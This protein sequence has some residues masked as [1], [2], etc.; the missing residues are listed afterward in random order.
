MLDEFPLSY[1][2]E[3]KYVGKNHLMMTG[4]EGVWDLKINNGKVNSIF[5][6]RDFGDYLLSGAYFVK[7]ADRLV[8]SSAIGIYTYEP[9]WN[10]NKKAP[11]APT[12]AEIFID[13]VKCN[14][15]SKASICADNTLSMY[16]RDVNWG[17]NRKLYYRLVKKGQK[18]NWIQLPKPEI[19]LSNLQKGKYTL[20][21]KSK[22][23]SGESNVAEYKLEIQPFWYNNNWFY[24]FVLFLS[25]IAIVIAFNWRSRLSKKKQIILSEIIKEKTKEIAKEKLQIESELEQKGILLKEVNHR[26]MNNMQMVSSVLELQSGRAHSEKEKETLT[27]AIQRVKAL[28][29]AHQHFYQKNQFEKINLKNYLEVILQ[30]LIDKKTIGLKFSIADDIEMNIEQAQ[31]LG[32]ILNELLSNSIKH[33]WSL[34]APDKKIDFKF[35]EEKGRYQFEYRDN[36]SGLSQDVGSSNGIGKMLIN[37]FVERKLNGQKETQNDNG[38]FV[39][40]SFGKDEK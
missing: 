20:G 26:V 28:A 19:R 4:S 14:N 6:G 31:T 3:A 9:F 8:Y 39:K 18:S 7:L 22:N 29:L 13:S 27:S 36:G 25:S 30:S 33:A 40:I 1:I 2:W 24:V 37:A 32:L 17:K 11:H 16:I 23:A 34:E 35:F 5:Y 10:S 15:I 38:Y 21:L 12:L